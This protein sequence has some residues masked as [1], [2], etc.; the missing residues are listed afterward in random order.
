MKRKKTLIPGAA[1]LIVLA[2]CLNVVI[3]QKSIQTRTYTELA[4]RG[5]TPQDVSGLSIHHSYLNR[6]LGY[7]EWTISVEFKKEP[8]ILFGFTY[9]DHKVVF[10]G[11]RST[12]ALD[13][14]E[15]LEYGERYENGTLLSE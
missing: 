3:T 4:S 10:E 6:I 8:D 15:T 1:V 9:R 11:V 12:P 5:C 14:E 2:L 13:K 7:N